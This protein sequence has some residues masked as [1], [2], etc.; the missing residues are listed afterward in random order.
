MEIDNSNTRN[1]IED[2]SLPKEPLD[3]KVI[4]ELAA[5]RKT[6]ETQIWSVG[7]SIT[8]G[9]GVNL[10][11]RYGQL[12]ANNLQLP[13]SFLSYPGASIPWAAD[14][15][16]RSDIRKND[17]VV[18]GLTTIQRFPYIY[19]KTL[20]HV[21]PRIVTTLNDPV[22][23]DRL[24]HDEL[25]YR[26]I[27]DIFKVINFCNKIGAELILANLLDST[28]PLYLHD[29]ES[30]IMLYGLHGTDVNNLFIDIGAAADRRHP[31]P[32]THK[33]YAEEILKKIAK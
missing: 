11:Q 18:W 6:N 14:Q 1:S 33:W 2:L 17:I 26:A 21:T 3:K 31:G 27:S 4:I 15:I 19:Y 25:V 8:H 20:V 32:K 24:V 5:G 28:L 13:V 23:I 7:C 9:V 22:L 29:Q 30:F 12:I 10:D 16:L